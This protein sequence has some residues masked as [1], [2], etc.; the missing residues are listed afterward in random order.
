MSNPFISHPIA[1]NFL[2]GSILGFIAMF[3]GTVAVTEAITDKD[4]LR[5]TGQHGVIFVLTVVG[6]AFWAK[7]IRDEKSRAKEDEARERR[8][9]E[10]LD[11]S[12][13]HFQML[14]TMNKQNAEDLKE[15]SIESIKAQMEGTSAIKAL[16]KELA[17][18]PCGMTKFP[19]QKP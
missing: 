16:T 18:R 17:G 15:V 3:N 9:M 1:S 2:E 10:S 8:H 5:L 6:L 7:S 4:W 19:I 11:A 12:E 13:K 14:T